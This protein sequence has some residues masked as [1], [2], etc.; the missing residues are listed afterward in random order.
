MCACVSNKDGSFDM[1]NT[2]LQGT[3]GRY[4]PAST[5]HGGATLGSLA[6]GNANV[7]FE[8]SHESI[9]KNNL[10]TLLDD[11]KSRYDAEDDVA[12]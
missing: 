1:L 9:Q 3:A 11:V 12:S 8:G 6:N 5:G 4:K 2:S 7:T 10:D